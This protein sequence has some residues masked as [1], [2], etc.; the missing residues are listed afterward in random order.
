MNQAHNTKKHLKNLIKI[1][2]KIAGL[3][4]IV[5][6]SGTYIGI[7]LDNTDEDFNFKQSEAIQML[8]EISPAI[9]LYEATSHPTMGNKIVAFRN[10]S[11]H[12]HVQ[13]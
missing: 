7:I 10:D 4:V 3:G 8:R 2:D 6:H 1:C 13:V 12:I 5:A 9:K 11:Q